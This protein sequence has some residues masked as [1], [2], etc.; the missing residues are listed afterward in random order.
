MSILKYFSVRT[1]KR[2]CLYSTQWL[3]HMLIIKHIKHKK[4]KKKKIKNKK[5][6]KN[7]KKTREKKTKIS[8]VQWQQI[9]FM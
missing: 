4:S 9:D 2:S 1:E 5:N 3:K 6:S 8:I 7:K